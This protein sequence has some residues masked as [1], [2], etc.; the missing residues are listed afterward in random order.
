MMQFKGRLIIQQFSYSKSCRE[1]K[2]VIQN[3]SPIDIF[4]KK[5]KRVGRQS[6]ID[7]RF[8]KLKKQAD[9][10]VEDKKHNS[11]KL[12]VQETCNN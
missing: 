9:K 10:K 1:K 2:T 7:I 11:T 6:K 8:E 3:L 12:L 4:I 5:V